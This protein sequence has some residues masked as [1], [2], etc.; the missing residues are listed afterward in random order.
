AFFILLQGVPHTVSLEDVCD[1]I[2][3][4]HGVLSVDELQIWQL[5]ESKI[6]ASVLHIMTSS[7]HDFMPTIAADIRKALHLNGIHSSNH[8]VRIPLSSFCH[9]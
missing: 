8:S 5:S 7:N 3:K 9:W 1:S 2:L 6:V 4:V